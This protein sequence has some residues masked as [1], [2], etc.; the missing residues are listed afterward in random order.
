MTL[1]VG[2]VG[3]GIGLKHLRSLAQIPDAQIVGIA[4]LLESRLQIFTSMYDVPGYTHWKDMLDADEQLDAVVLATPARVRL[5][6][7]E[8]I[9]KRRLAL[10]CEKPPAID[11]N[12][13]LKVLR[14]IE[15]ANIINMVGFQYRWSPTVERMR[16]LIQG[17]RP[18]FA[19]IVVAV[20]WPTVDWMIPSPERHLYSK[21][22]TGG[23]L[24]DHGIHFQDMLHYITKDEPVAMQAMAELG[25][26]QSQEGRDAEETIVATI[27]YRSGMLLTQVQC[28]AYQANLVQL[29]I[30]G[31]DFDLTWALEDNEKLT[32]II[33]SRTISERL[34][35]TIDAQKIDEVDYTNPYVEE[36]RCFVE[37]ARTKNQ[38]L[39][40][41]SF[42]DACHTLAVCETATQAVESGALLPHTFT[43]SLDLD[44]E[45][46]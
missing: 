16:M 46:A 18:L 39:I 42:A 24:I 4:D 6:P 30:V 40:R 5:E 19:R 33:N 44:K 37:A 17:H 22:Q 34:T 41:A 32:G 35:G 7:I 10:F 1:R 3:L 29:Q 2:V 12:T 28:W 15:Q 26:T 14:L 13:A 38:S 9:C 21:K 25:W 31:E 20:P 45:F 11:L 8:E 27:K 36:M 23:P 43:Q